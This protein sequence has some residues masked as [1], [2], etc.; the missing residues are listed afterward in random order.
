MYKEL[1]T[2][3]RVLDE[4]AVSKESANDIMVKID[5]ELDE[6]KY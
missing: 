2:D 1:T 3:N 6:V 4:V 5:R